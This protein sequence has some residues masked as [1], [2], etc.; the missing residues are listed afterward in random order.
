MK[1]TLLLTPTLILV[2]ASLAFGQ[3]NTFHGDN[4]RSGATNVIGPVTPQLRWSVELG[5]PIISSPVVGPD[6]TIVLGSVLKDQLHP[7][8]FITAV[9]PD[10]SI[11]WQVE[12]GFRFTQVQSTPAFGPDG[13]VYVGAQDGAF[14]AIDPNGA[15][16]WKIETNR[17][18]RQHPVVA[19]SGTIYIGAQGTLYALS[20][21]GSI[22][23]QYEVGT[24]DLPGGPSLGDDG[25]IYA[26]GGTQSV[27][28]KVYAFNPDGTIR[29]TY[30][31]WNPDWM[32]LSPPTIGPDGSVIVLSDRM[33]VFTAAGTL[34]WTAWPHFIGV[35]T[36][37]SATVDPTGNVY[38]A[39]SYNLY[40][41]SPTGT[42]LWEQRLDDPGSSFLGHSFS[43]IL[44]DG[45]GNLYM[46]LGHGR[47]SAIDYE[48][49][50]EIR[51]STTGTVRGS[52][53]LPEA[54]GTSSPA[55]AADGTMYIGCFDGKL[56]ALI[57]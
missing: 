25:A 9:R 11:R 36:Y 26:A 42:L 40:K 29:W 10:G 38:F 13:T 20:Q 46:G 37:A 53:V 48:K 57:E 12:T 15:V 22:L 19:P 27:E 44:I 47:R 7:R 49:R 4:K 45:A 23:W 33:Y 18:I 30:A 35:S 28:S 52:F 50:L 17:P 14:Y 8:Y 56:Y 32:T 24:L 1:R 16:R 6:G 31:M 5:G 51:R 54:V 39:E 21:N 34:K 55:L 41:Y 2:A 43:S 3:W